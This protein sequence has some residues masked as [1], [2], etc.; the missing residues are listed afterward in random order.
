[1]SLHSKVKQFLT[2]GMVSKEDLSAFIYCDSIVVKALFYKLE[3]RG[4]KTQRGV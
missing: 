1:M 2:W 3:G 4:I